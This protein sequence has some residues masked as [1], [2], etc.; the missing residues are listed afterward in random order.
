MELFE[1]IRKKLKRKSPA[2]N[3]M[4]GKCVYPLG[5]PKFEAEINIFQMLPINKIFVVSWM[6]NMVTDTRKNFP[7]GQKIIN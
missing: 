2:C 4:I 6:E 3:Q 7:C 5:Y 1:Y